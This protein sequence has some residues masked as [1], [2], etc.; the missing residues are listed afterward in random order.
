MT[1][2]GR[3]LID[4]GSGITEVPADH[5]WTRRHT[6]VIILIACGMSNDEIAVRLHISHSTVKHHIA[7]MCDRYLARNR[8]HLVFIAMRAGVIA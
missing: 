7:N 4:L 5:G 2:D 1:T 3:T 6:E 8:A